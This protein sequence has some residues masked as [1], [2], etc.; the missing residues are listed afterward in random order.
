MVENGRGSLDR[1]RSNEKAK[2]KVEKRE[3]KRRRSVVEKK[4]SN[5]HC[6]TSKST[7]VTKNRYRCWK[8]K[9]LEDQNS[10][11]IGSVSFN[12]DCKL[13]NTAIRN[14]SVSG[15]CSATYDSVEMREVRR[16]CDCH[17]GTA[18][19]TQWRDCW[20]R[21][22]RNNIDRCV[23]SFK[24]NRDSLTRHQKKK[25]TVRKCVCWLKRKFEKDRR[26]KID[27]M[28]VFGGRKTE[29]SVG[30]QESLSKKTAIIMKNT[31]FLSEDE[32]MTRTRGWKVQ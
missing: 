25:K 32:S 31:F 9:T 22:L 3:L 7:D 6:V 28:K 30:S 16:L 1:W 4:I 10:W 18:L 17:Y 11:L 8:S 14:Q 13:C 5:E 12:V 24:T 29:E 26:W 23:L 27:T 15:N 21:D 19:V 2:K 20:T